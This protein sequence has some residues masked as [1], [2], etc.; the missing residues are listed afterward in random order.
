M[1]LSFGEMVADM[2]DN[3][4]II[5]FKV[6]DIMCGPMVE[7]MKEPGKTTKW[8]EEASLH[9][10][11]EENTKGSMLMTRNKAMVSSHGQIAD[12]IRVDGRMEN[13]MAKVSTKIPQERKGRVC[14][15]TEKRWDG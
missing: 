9:G 4:K 8:T 12:V 14:G 11:M 6:L 3:L 10:Q 5:I 7:S 15:Q 13:K 2:M 1:V